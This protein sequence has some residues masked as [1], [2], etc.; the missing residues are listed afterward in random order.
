MTKTNSDEIYS[1]NGKD[2]I[3]NHFFLNKKRKERLW[4]VDNNIFFDRLWLLRSFR[5]FLNNSKIETYKHA[6]NLLEDEKIV[7]MGQFSITIKDLPPVYISKANKKKKTKHVI[8]ET[9]NRTLPQPIIMR[10]INNM[11][12]TDRWRALR[13]QALKLYTPVCC[14]CGL[15]RNNGAVLHVDHIKPKS[16]YPELQWD[17]NNLQILCEDCNLGKSNFDTTDWRLK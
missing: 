7:L 14:L 16:L 10:K 1:F 6:K 15:D 8:Q 9:I 11:T 5:Q 2:E 12:D 17:L 13:Y 3:I 4:R